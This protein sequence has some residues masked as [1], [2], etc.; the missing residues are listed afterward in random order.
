MLWSRARYACSGS[1]DFEVDVEADE[2]EERQL[3]VLGRRVV[4]VGD[5]RVPVD[6]PS[7]SSQS[8]SMKRSIFRLPC[9]RTIEAGISLPTA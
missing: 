8:R 6:L 3:E 1:S 7:R 5:E 2:I 9:H 4:D